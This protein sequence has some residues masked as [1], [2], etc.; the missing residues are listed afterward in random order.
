MQCLPTRPFPG[1]AKERGHPRW[2]R[3]EPSL[4]KSELGLSFAP[5]TLERDRI[6][7]LEN[8]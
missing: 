2:M 1:S 4:D 8:R 5:Q 7:D 6:C 3:G